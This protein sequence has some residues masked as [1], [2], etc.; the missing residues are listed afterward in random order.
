[1]TLGNNIK[2]LVILIPKEGHHQEGEENEALFLDKHFVPDNVAIN[3][4]TAVLWFNGVVGYERTVDVKDAQSYPVFNKGAI[5]I[6]NP[7]N[8]SPLTIL[9]N[10]ITKQKVILV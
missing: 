9:D 10:L 6:V 5:L 8:H 7:L 2:T 1:M 3:S 4:G